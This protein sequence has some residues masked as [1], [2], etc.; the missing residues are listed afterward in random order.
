[1][2]FSSFTWN[3][4]TQTTL[5]CCSPS[6]PSGI[7]SSLHSTAHCV[8]LIASLH[9]QQ[10]SLLSKAPCIMQPALHCLR[11]AGLKI[12][13]LMQPIGFLLSVLPAELSN[14]GL[15]EEEKNGGLTFRDR[16]LT[17]TFFVCY[18]VSTSCIIWL[19][20]NSY[21]PKVFIS[22]TKFIKLCPS[23]C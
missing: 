16:G 22:I 19:F 11:W 12:Q 14:Q 6:R 8:P 20:E 7:F 15:G 23:L 2:F 3:I 1:M 9:V 17:S 18:H 4:H 5:Y 21:V 10:L 13:Q